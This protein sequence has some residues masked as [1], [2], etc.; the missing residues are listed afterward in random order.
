MCIVAFLDSSY[1]F[2][3]QNCCLTKAAG[4]KMGDRK[5]CSSSQRLCEASYTALLIYSTKHIV[6]VTA[7]TLKRTAHHLQPLSAAPRFHVSL[8][9]RI[10][11][12]FLQAPHKF[13]KRRE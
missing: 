8:D 7:V 3:Q 9:P 1:S 11:R 13:N 5:D 6:S 2:A 10:A 4:A 12:L